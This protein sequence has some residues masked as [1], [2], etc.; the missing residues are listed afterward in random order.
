MKIIAAVNPSQSCLHRIFV[1]SDLH[2][3][4]EYSPDNQ[5]NRRGFRICT[6]TRRLAAF[7]RWVIQ[8]GGAESICELVINGDFLDFLAEKPDG[9]LQWQPFITDGE[10]A[11]KQLSIMIERDRIVFDALK[12]LLA[13]GHRLT[14]LLSNHDAELSLPP[15]RQ[16]F[17]RELETEG[18]HFRFI[19]DNQAY[20]VGSMII[21]HGNRYDGWNVIDH[22]GLRRT[23]SA[24]S[25][26]E[27]LSQ[28]RAF[29][30][31]AGSVMVAT[32]MNQIKERFPFVDL[33]KPE[34][35]ATLP[36]LLT[37]APQYREHLMK[38]I[39]LAIKAQGHSLDAHGQPIFAG[40]VR[41][42]GLDPADAYLA[43][44]LA[45]HVSDPEVREFVKLIDEF[46]PR[47]PGGVEDEIAWK[48]FA[49]Y[50][51]LVPII[52]AAPSA[53]LASRL[54]ALLTA[55]L[56]LRDE[57][58]FD[59]SQ[60]TEQYLEAARKLIDRGF[61]V[62]VFGHTHLAKRVSVG[63]GIYLNTGTWADLI[64]FPYEQLD[65][66]RHHVLQWL[67]GFAG[68]MENGEISQYIS[69]MPTYARI[70]LSSE[71]KVLHA[72]IHDF[73]EGQTVV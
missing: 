43:G 69:H 28:D 67:E 39:N 68:A 7:I 71:G 27:A 31:P 36:L 25:R 29:S 24:Q 53:P 5:A 30:A 38:V 60:E 65:K 51:S 44:I 22:D 19:F 62:V 41:A 35:E 63:D 12:D 6:Q 15:V 49:D 48:G 47:R 55:L 46:A 58:S 20:V 45:A 70:D 10:R 23:R 9:N 57:R 3:G 54:P 72:A 59:R 50:L 42:D 21:E 34:N 8:E 33:L 2:L 16:L 32:V 26:G 56:T 64:R 40:D 52:I 61:N 1:I 14:I 11:A 4:G 18:R 37:L 66:E 13:A 17:E 73:A